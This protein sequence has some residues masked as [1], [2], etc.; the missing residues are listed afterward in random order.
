LGVF[1]QESRNF[2]KVENCLKM[3]G[4]LTRISLQLLMKE[5]LEK[6]INFLLN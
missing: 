3:Y 1:R 5:N 2:L 4:R 6:G